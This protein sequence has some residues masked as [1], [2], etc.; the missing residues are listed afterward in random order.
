M[1]SFFVQRKAWAWKPPG[2]PVAVLAKPVMSPRSLTDIDVFQA[3]PP[4]SPRFVTVPRSHRTAWR[5]L[6]RPTERS[7]MPEMPTTWPRSLMAVA[8]LVVSP[9]SGGGSLGAPSGAPP[10]AADYK[11][12]RADAL[13]TR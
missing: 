10:S 2:V 8:A 3:T 13:G 7:Q 11:H 5:A 1:P 4:R 6:K 9:G 12:H